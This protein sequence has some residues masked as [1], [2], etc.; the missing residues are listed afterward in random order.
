MKELHNA[1]ENPEFMFQDYE[2]PK[3]F[4]NHGLISESHISKDIYEIAADIND[5]GLDFEIIEA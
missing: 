3:F 4:I 5:S 1:D 2:F